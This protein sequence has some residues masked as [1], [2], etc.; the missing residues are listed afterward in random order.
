VYELGDWFWID[1]RTVSKTLK[2]CGVAMHRRGPSPEQ[3]DEA[4]RLYEVGWFLARVGEWIGIDPT[5]VLDR[6]RDC[7][8]RDEG[9]AWQGT[10]ERMSSGR[11]G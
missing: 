5:T 6:L 11:R 4:V 7:G 2:R 1:R 9:C 10:G 3:V 8:V